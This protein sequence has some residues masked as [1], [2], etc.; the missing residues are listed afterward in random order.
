MMGGP[1][2]F[3]MMFWMPIGVLL[4]VVVFAFVI[5]LVVRFLNGQR[6]P[7]TPY[8]PH[9]QDFSRPYQQGY[10]PPEQQ[11][12]ETYQEGGQQY[13]Y[14]Q[15]KQEYDQPQA[16]YPQQQELPPQQ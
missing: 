4:C 12:P 10:Q 2:M 13:H 7:M 11:N 14:P 9:G 5:W 6:T 16:H 1:G 8:T 3:S 15:P